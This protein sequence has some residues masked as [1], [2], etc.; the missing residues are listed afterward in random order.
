MPRAKRNVA[1]AAN[2]A[3]SQPQSGGSTRKFPPKLKPRKRILKIQR[4]LLPSEPSETA[5]T[6]E[7]S[8]SSVQGIV[9]FV[10]NI[11]DAETSTKTKAT[12]T[13][14]ETL[15][16]RLPSEPSEAGETPEYSLSSVQDIVMFAH[17]IPELMA[18]LPVPVSIPEDSFASDTI[19]THQ[20]A[21]I[22]DRY[23]RDLGKATTKK[24]Q[25]LDGNLFLTSSDFLVAAFE[26][27][28]C[29]QCCSSE[30]LRVTSQTEVKKGIFAFGLSCKTCHAKFTRMS[31][32]RIIESKFRPMSWLPN[33]LLLYFFLNGEYYKDY[34]HVL[35]KL[36]IG[37]LSKPQW[38]RVVRWVHP[39]VKRLAIWS[40]SEVKREIIRQGDQSNLKIMFDG[41]YLT[42]GYHANNA[43]GTIHDEETGKIIEFVHRSKRGVGSNWTG[44]S[45]GAKGTYLRRYL[46]VFRRTTSLSR[47][48]RWTTIPHAS[49]FY[50]TSSPRPRWCT[51]AITQ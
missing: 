44:T 13:D 32:S 19:Y 48:A 16:R 18:N 8:L 7:Y 21:G 45:G 42:R 10:H 9:T 12:Q 5:E 29:E 23:C 43:S 46:A 30:G 49:M 51:V 37:S 2:K 38:Q 11:P 31:D 35:G 14:D 36:G 34:E 22:L 1:K 20:I 3:P 28:L 15:Q 27:Q 33:Y 41:F 4:C 47:N 25:V 26:S 24:L 6:P 17:N 50:W 39:F 40:C